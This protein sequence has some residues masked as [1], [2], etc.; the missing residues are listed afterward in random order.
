MNSV[1]FLQVLALLAG[2]TGCVSSTSPQKIQPVD[3]T[4]SFGTVRTNGDGLSERDFV[5]IAAR[6]EVIAE[7][8]CLEALARRNC[9]FLIIIDDRAHQPSNAF[10]FITENSRPVLAV[11]VSLLD[12]VQND[13]E[14]AFVIG[15]EAAHHVAGHIDQQ[16][17]M[18]NQGALLG[19]F[20]A[21]ILGADAEAIQTA[22]DIGAFVGSRQF[23]KQHELEA[24]QLGAVIALKAG[25]DPEKGV[26]YF[27][28]IPDPGEEFLGSHPSNADRIEAVQSAVSGV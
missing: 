20:T 6:V 8:E 12:E 9:D 28:R 5:R 15:H 24:D 4:E 25:F 22:R 26:T 19:S 14:L 11:T 13:D 27:T 17:A 21:A 2:V 23:S 7:A 1:K 18:A 16:M 3:E 10:Q